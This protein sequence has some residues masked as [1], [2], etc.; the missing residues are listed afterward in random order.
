MEGNHWDRD[1]AIITKISQAFI[2]Y[3][4]VV[5]LGINFKA[6]LVENKNGTCPKLGFLVISTQNFLAEKFYVTLSQ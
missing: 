2:P 1:W 6:A 3:L 5:S 4:A